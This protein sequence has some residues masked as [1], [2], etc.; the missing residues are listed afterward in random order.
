MKRVLSPRGLP[1]P[2]RPVELQESEARH[3][4]QVLRLRSGSL[5]EALDG[6][7]HAAP[8]RLLVRGETAL[9]E[10][11]EGAGPVARSEPA[12]SVLPVTLELAALKGDAMAW[13]IEKAV[14][15]GAHELLPVLTDHTVV[16]VREKGPQAFRVRWQKIAD[17]ALK[18]CGRLESMEVLEPVA[19]RDLLALHPSGDRSPRLWFDEE[20]R[21]QAPH[22]ASWLSGRSV[23]EARLL[24]GPEGGWSASERELL[25]RD[26]AV[27]LSLGPLVLRAETAAL[28][29][30]SV[31]AGF[32]R[33]AGADPR[34]A[35]RA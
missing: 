34:A 29:S 14:E 35:A 4:I 3:A 11:V 1:S 21:D 6:K 26:R 9:L 7:G 20:G 10:H 25:L 33:E 24:I 31:L 28:F 12:G 15:L 23:P 16:Q 17:Q 2:G 27:R 30:L 13:A 8:A 18:Q 32:L 22:L 5:V 19:L